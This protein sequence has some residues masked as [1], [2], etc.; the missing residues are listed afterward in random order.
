MTAHVVRIRD[1]T[2]AVLIEGRGT[3]W[4]ASG[5]FG[6]EIIKVIAA[7]ERAALKR[8]GEAALLRL[9]AIERKG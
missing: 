6:G 3:N 4:A 7:S 8:W 5:E 9:D 2:Y 1:V